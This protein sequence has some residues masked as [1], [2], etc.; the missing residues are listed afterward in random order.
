MD[1]AEVVQ[2]IQNS[3]IDESAK[4][5]LAENIWRASIAS[6]CYV[7]VRGPEI[8][9]PGSGGLD[10]DETIYNG[11]KGI[12]VDFHRVHD[13]LSN[14]HIQIKAKSLQSGH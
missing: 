8:H 10:F 13:A 6:I 3:T 12:K 5:V 14:I 11:K 1:E 9:G 4:R 7:H 2:A